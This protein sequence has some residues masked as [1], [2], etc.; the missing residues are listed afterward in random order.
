[1]PAHH[2]GDWLR[3]H[4]RPFRST[5]HGR[6]RLTSFVAVLPVPCCGSVLATPFLTAARLITAAFELSWLL[7]VL[8]FVLIEPPTAVRHRLADCRCLAWRTSFWAFGG[9]SLNG[10]PCGFSWLPEPS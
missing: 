5:G 6:G 10:A 9:F 8:L 2:P 4:R 1:M 7:L 3:S